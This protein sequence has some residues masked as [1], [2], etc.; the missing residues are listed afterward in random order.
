MSTNK[1]IE[2]LFQERLKNLEVSPNKKVWKEIESKLAKKKRKVFPFWWFSSGV[3]AIL[4]LG[5]FIFPFSKKPSENIKKQPIIIAAPN[6]KQENFNSFKKEI[7]TIFKKKSKE[8]ILVKEDK[9]RKKIHQKKKGNKE[10][11]NFLIAQKNTSNSNKQPKDSVSKNAMKKFF[12]TDNPKSQ[13]LLTQEKNI[14]KIDTISTTK[15][16]ILK[17]KKDIFLAVNK[18]DKKEKTALKKNWSISSVFAV[19]NSNSFSN[20]SPIDKNLSNSTT[21]NSSYSYGVKIAYQLNNKW[22][23]QSGIHL[24]EIQFSNNQIVVNSTSSS[25]SNIRFNSGESYSLLGISNEN[26]DA[27]N[28]SGNALSLNGKLSQIYG[29]VE[30]PV[31]IK[32]NLLENKKIKTQVV[33]GFSSLFL[34]KNTIKLNTNFLSQSGKAD[35][36]NSINFS[37]NLGIDFNYML[38]KN[39]SINLNPMLKTQVNTFHKNANGFKPYFIGI[40]SG[41]NYQF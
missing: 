39:W 23:I 25:A 18:I 31:E 35:N 28:L 4:I 9:K 17:P 12:I 40:Y 21:G 26:F 36:L 22:A 16:K 10:N 11:N 38:N 8:I 33:A 30:I 29:Y 2:R 37:G 13:N 5:L 15:K 27:V 34:N 32:Y 20:S 3:A 7:D 41:I 14:H 1:K 24:Q 6:K 19:L